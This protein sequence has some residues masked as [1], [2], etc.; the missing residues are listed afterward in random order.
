ML[1]SVTRLPLQLAAGT[2]VLNIRFGKAL[3]G[4]SEGRRAIRDL[5]TTYFDLG[6]MQIQLSVVD[7][8][9]LE[10]AV[11][12]PERHEDLIVRVGGFS[13]YFNTLSPTLKQAILERTEHAL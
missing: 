6:G 2:P 5:I 1:R 7:R 8:E 13:A 11:M 12:H 9:V 10:D 3:F 4:S